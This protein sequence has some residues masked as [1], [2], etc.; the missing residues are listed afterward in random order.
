V[1]YSDHGSP[2]LL[3]MPVGTIYA[4]KL[5]QTINTMKEKN[6]FS[7]LV[8]YIEACHAGSMFENILADNIKVYATAASSPHESSWGCY[9]HPEDIVNGTHIRSCLG[10]LYSVSWMETA[11]V[12]D[13]T[14]QTVQE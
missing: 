12:T 6:M 2:G 1:F 7:E 5:N 4:D 3:A 13:L 11:E 10:D 8:I 9:C 14:K